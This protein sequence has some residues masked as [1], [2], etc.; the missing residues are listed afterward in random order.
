[1]S[2]RDAQQLL[3]QSMETLEGEAVSFH[4][5]YWGLVQ[6]LK[7]NQVHRHSFFEI[8]FCTGGLGVYMDDGRLHR[9]EAGTMFCSRPGVFHQII[10]EADSPLDL[11][12]VAFEVLP[13]SSKEAVKLFRELA[14]CENYFQ[15]G[16][17]LS[18]AALLWQCILQQVIVG[19][20]LVE[21]ALSGMCHTLLSSLPEIFLK[22]SAEP[23]ERPRNRAAAAQLNQAKLFIRDNLGGPL[24]LEQVARYV[25]M[26]GR[27]LTR[28]FLAEEGKTVVAYIRGERVR[29][30][31]AL[32]SQDILT[33]QEIAEETGFGNVHYFTRVFNEETGMPPARFRRLH[34]E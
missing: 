25:H 20:P 28:M 32:L 23:R 4:V 15:P 22:R 14:V 24:H 26:S 19:R 34:R 10:P 27:H 13:S 29:L 2:W 7:A 11:L 21:S 16:K 30:A 5:H 12:Y 31:Q 18:P 8:C 3:N 9:I 6:G 33:I 17:S 1:M